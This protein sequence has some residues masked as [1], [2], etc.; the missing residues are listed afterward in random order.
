MQEPKSKPG[1]SL[2]KQL[3]PGPLN[4]HWTH[5]LAREGRDGPQSWMTKLRLPE[6]VQ[7]H[8]S[9]CRPVPEASSLHFQPS[10]VSKSHCFPGRL[11]DLG[12]PKRPPDLG[13]PPLPSTTTPVPHTSST[14]MAESTNNRG[15]PETSPANGAAPR[16][17]AQ[18]LLMGQTA[19]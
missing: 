12:L 8:G 11:C 1:Q 13:P 3:R 19:C 7:R 18:E 16:G 15:A 5:M 10:A 14:A 6:V 2:E 17:G 9:P 4:V